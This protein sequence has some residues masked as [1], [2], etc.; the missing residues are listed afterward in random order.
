MHTI[1]AGLQAF[2]VNGPVPTCRRWKDT[3]PGTRDQAAYRLYI[4]ARKL[5]RSKIAW[6]LTRQE[7]TSILHD[8]QSAA[9]QGDWGARA[10][11]AHFYRSGLGPLDTNHV[12]DIDWTNQS[13]S[14]VQPSQPARPGD[15]TISVSHTSK[16]MAVLCRINGSRGPIT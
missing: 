14:F 4:D 10:L 7:F 6:Q 12:L 5:W 11:M 9:N 3:M 13:T 1:P 8:V 15:T 2:D 16:A